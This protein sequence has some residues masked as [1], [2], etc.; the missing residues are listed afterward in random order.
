MKSW[1]RYCVAVYMGLLMAGSLFTSR[2]AAAGPTSLVPL[3]HG[4]AKQ[5]VCEDVPQVAQPAKAPHQ[6]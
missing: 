2:Q 4:Q 6:D 1:V 3:G 5:S